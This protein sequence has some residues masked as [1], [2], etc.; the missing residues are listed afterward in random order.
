VANRLASSGV[1]PDRLTLEL[2][3]TGLVTDPARVAS[4]LHQ[5]AAM[6]VRTSIDDF[7]TGYSSLSRLSDLPVAE[8]KID[9]SFVFAMAGGGGETLVRSIVDLGHNLNLRVVAEGVEDPVTIERLR[10]LRC[11]AVQG[12]HLSRALSAPVFEAWLEERKDVEVATSAVIVP[13][14]K[15]RLAPG[16]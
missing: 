16:F 2:T 4:V 1:N 12:Y 11:N 10:Q 15:A 13:L 6:G 9:K 8:V 3:E 5:L 14:R 7:G